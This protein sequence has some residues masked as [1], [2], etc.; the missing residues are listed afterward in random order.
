MAQLVQALETRWGTLTEIPK[1]GSIVRV[2]F[3]DP[4]PYLELIQRDDGGG[5]P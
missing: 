1:A 5:A 4:A 3:G 2:A